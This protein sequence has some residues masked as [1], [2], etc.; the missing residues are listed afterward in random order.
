MDFAME[1]TLI[2]GRIDFSGITSASG[3][4]FIHFIPSN[5]AL[6]NKVEGNYFYNSE[7]P[8]SLLLDGIDVIEM[9]FAD[10]EEQEW[11]QS[12]SENHQKTSYKPVIEDKNQ[13]LQ[14]ENAFEIDAFILIHRL[15]SENQAPVFLFVGKTNT[16]DG[17]EFTPMVRTIQKSMNGMI[18]SRLNSSAFAGEQ[19]LKQASA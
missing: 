5:P 16:S 13:I 17:H 19:P 15:I 11:W 14:S 6:V 2:K 10:K 4:S 9:E 18:L 7:K 1:H 12:L 3:D 8:L